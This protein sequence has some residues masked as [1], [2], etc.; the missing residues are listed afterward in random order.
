VTRSPVEHGAAEAVRNEAAYAQRP[1]PAT[2]GPPIAFRGKNYRSPKSYQTGTHRSESPDATFSLIEPYLRLAGV[3]R[4]ADV[5]GL[6]QVG[7]PT[8]LAIRPNS[9]TIACS[10]GKGITFDQARVSGAMEAFELHAAET[11]RPLSIRASYR[12]LCAA[13]ENAPALRDLPLSHHS[14]F[15]EEWPFHWHLGWDIIHQ[16]ECP[17]PLA[18][19][20][21]SRASGLIESMGVFQVTSNGLGAGNSFLEA[22]A[23][24]LYEVIERDAFA[25]HYAAAL[26]RG[27]AIPRVPDETLRSYALVA[28]VLDRC[29]RARIGVVVQDCTI[30]TAIPTYNAIVYDHED[31]GV[32]IVHGTGSHLDPEVALL[33][34][35]TEALQ[36]RLNF[37]AGSR[38]DIFRAA[39]RRWRG[40]RERLMKALDASKAESPEAQALPSRASA[41]FEDDI[42]ILVSSLVAAGLSAAVVTDITPPQFPVHVVRVVVPGLEGYMHHSYRPGH[43]AMA[44]RGNCGSS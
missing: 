25:C 44:F 26:R 13:F 27:H 28:G 1:A 31:R 14:V 3:T 32:G 6:D 39:F 41:T 43:R 23:S 19:V 12:E 11:V 9:Q 21:M 34:A 35:V 2:A 37:I 17:I 24:A 29:D 10:S 38:D 4:I 36:A 33:R 18:T 16:R 40:D 22:L 8:V 20:G 30:D 7:V 5:T 42:A 15:G